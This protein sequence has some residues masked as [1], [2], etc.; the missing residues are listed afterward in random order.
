MEEV[1]YLF[2]KPRMSFGAAMCLS[3]KVIAPEIH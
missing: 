1:A 3:M 2:S